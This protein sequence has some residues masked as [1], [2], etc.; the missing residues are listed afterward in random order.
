MSGDLFTEWWE[1]YQ[2]DRLTKFPEF[3][4][5]DYYRSGRAS[6]AWPEKE[7]KDWWLENG[8]RFVSLWETWRDASDLTFAEFPGD[9]GEAVPGIELEVWADNGAGLLVK[10][11]IDRVM[12]DGRGQLY[13]VDLKTGSHTDP[14][15]LQMALNN[16]CLISTYGISADYAGFWSARKGGVD[17]WFP[18]SRYSED[19]LWDIVGKAKEIRD[20]QLFI[21]NPNNLCKSACGVRAHC[22]AMGGKPFFSTSHATMTQGR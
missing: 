13:I 4:P 12:E 8:P 6:K 17:E 9:G 16:L 19:M 14:W 22:P 15:P 18:L 21:P 3:G 2:E 20:R 7:N 11:V 10:S 5:E 1:V